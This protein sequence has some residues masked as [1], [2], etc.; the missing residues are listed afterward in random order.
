[1]SRAYEPHVVARWVRAS[2]YLF[3]TGFPQLILGTAFLAAG[4]EPVLGTVL[5]LVLFG[6]GLALLAAASA[7]V[8]IYVRAKAR[9]RRAP[10]PR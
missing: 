3:T 8:V 2:P 6:S 10:S 9:D 5:G 4:A 1:M 7:S